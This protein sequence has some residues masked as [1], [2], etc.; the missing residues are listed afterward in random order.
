M[1]TLVLIRKGVNVG[2]VVSMIGMGAFL[3]IPATTYAA[4]D[5]FG[6]NSTTQVEQ[7]TSSNKL[8]RLE[9][10]GIQ[11]NQPFLPE[12]IDYSAT[13]EN[14]VETIKL[15]AETDGVNS[16]LTV[17]GNPI[18]SMPYP[19]HTGE[20]VFLITVDDGVNSS[21]TYTLTVIKKQNSNAL[22]QNILLSKGE[23]SPA[24]DPEISSYN[25]HVPN[26]VDMLGITPL[27]YEKTSSIMVKNTLTS[28]TG[29]SVQIPVGKTEVPIM[30]TAENGVKKIYTLEVIRDSK[31][32][33]TS[34]VKS[35]GGKKGAFSG[36]KAGVGISNTTG[37]QT[38]QLQGN[39]NKTQKVSLATLSKLT[40]SKGTWNKTFA[41]TEFTY[42]IA[43]DTDITS[44]TINESSSNSDATISIE[45]GISNT[46]QLGN[47]KKTVISV[48]VT[49]GEE[50]KTYVLVFD[51][52]IK[53]DTVTSSDTSEKTSSA[54]LTNS[55]TS[56]N[57]STVKVSSWN[58]KKNNTSTSWWGRFI[59]SIRSIF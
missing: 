26:E 16:V 45:G 33:E 44:V 11:L 50:H 37:K 30:V 49:K 39:A 48:V 43:E 34:P 31:K 55:T 59:N 47:N 56:T 27:P 12:V 19:V 40:T 54:N 51:K 24:F 15:L 17:N 38:F 20:N 46:I 14:N 29:T 25:V 13:V 6:N 52:D 9:L 36:V 18:S 5:E 8:S 42:H 1:R 41:S 28:D 3:Y 32:A 57:S 2:L 21:N 10:E 4:G 23:L 7:K 35:N 22:L 58:G 53:Q